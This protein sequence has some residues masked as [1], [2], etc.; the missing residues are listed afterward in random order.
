MTGSCNQRGSIYAL[1]DVARRRCLM[2]AVQCFRFGPIASFCEIRGCSALPVKAPMLSG[3]M[4]KTCLAPGP[5]LPRLRRQAGPSG[6]RAL[7]S[8]PATAIH[9]LDLGLLGLA[10]PLP[11]NNATAPCALRAFISP[12]SSPV[13]A[14]HRWND[15]LVALLQAI[16]DGDSFA[17]EFV[18][19]PPRL[20][21]SLADLQAFPAYFVYSP[22]ATCFAAIASYS[23]ELGLCPFPRRRGPLSTGPAGSL[24]LPLISAAVGNWP[25]PSAVAASPWCQWPDSPVGLQPSA[26]SM[27]PLPKAG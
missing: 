10:N 6:G 24:P 15:E 17:A 2:L 8:P 5:A 27:T 22:P 20:G 1:D 16:A 19:C 12:K 3:A 11:P 7:H 4:S 13:Y 9:G 23:G 26:P 18:T 14:F 21:K 25:R